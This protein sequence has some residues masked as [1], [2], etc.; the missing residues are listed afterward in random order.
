MAYCDL[1]KDTELIV[2]ASPIGLGAILAPKTCETGKKIVEYAGRSI[3]QR[4]FQTER[5]AL[6]C[7]LVCERDNS[8]TLSSLS[9]C[10]SE[11]RLEP[12]K[13]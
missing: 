5:K 10:K 1:E 4:Y 11:N 8:K 7:V 6:A 3:E 13:S 9:I 12:L 2:D